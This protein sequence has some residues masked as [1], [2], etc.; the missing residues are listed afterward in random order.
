MRLVLLGPP[1]AG[2]GT[3]AQVLAR[4]FR[5]PAIST[6]E[7][8]RATAVDDTQLGRSVHGHLVAGRLVPDTVTNAVVAGRLAEP[9]ASA[10]FVLDGFPRTR[11]QAY[12]LD[13]M[14]WGAGAGL[15]VAVVLH[16]ADD[17]VVRRLAGRRTCRS[18]GSVW[19]VEFRPTRCA[20]RCDRCGHELYQRDD[21]TASAIHARL[22]AYRVQT[23]PLLAFYAAGERLVEV[24]ASG[25]A[26]DVTAAVLDALERCGTGERCP[27]ADPLTGRDAHIAHR[28]S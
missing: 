18:C 8:F 13:R 17:A 4:R 21:D 11:E 3:Q 24:A 1:G 27:V 20:G 12:R 25:V 14:L 19:H 7:L 22:T 26:E 5:V 9:D 23:T 15:D 6:G 28:A 2:K 16:L 10:G